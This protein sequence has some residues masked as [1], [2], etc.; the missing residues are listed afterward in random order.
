M[1]GEK[2]EGFRFGERIRIVLSLAEEIG[3]G[4]AERGRDLLHAALR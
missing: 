3:G 2:A 1:I 4:H